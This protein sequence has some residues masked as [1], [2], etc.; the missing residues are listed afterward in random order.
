MKAS[1]R[2]N[3]HYSIGKIDK[4]IYGSF[5]EHLGRAVYSGIYEPDHKQADENGFRKDV[6]ALVKAVNVPIVRWP[7]GNFVSNYYF[8]VDCFFH[9]VLKLLYVY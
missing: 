5:I 2:V 9:L 4:R 6:I 3:K 1:I 8:F 7:G